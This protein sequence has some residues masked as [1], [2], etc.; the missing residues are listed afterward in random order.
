ML[1]SDYSNVK[2]LLR[3]HCCIVVA[4]YLSLVIG[5]WFLVTGCWLPVYL[6]KVY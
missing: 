5:Y 1:S 2:E 3:A 4:K 6:P